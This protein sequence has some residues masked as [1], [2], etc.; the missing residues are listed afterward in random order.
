MDDTFKGNVGK[1]KVIFKDKGKG[2]HPY[3]DVPK[4]Y[5]KFARTNFGL[6]IPEND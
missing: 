4:K 5:V 1:D 6:N 2:K 3:F